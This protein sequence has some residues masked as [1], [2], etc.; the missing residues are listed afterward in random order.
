[1]RPSRIASVLFGLAV[2]TA[3][4]GT[5]R[6]DTAA[7]TPE[8]ATPQASSPTAT[9]QPSSPTSTAEVEVERGGEPVLVTAVRFAAHDG[10]DRV[11]VDFDGDVPGYRV[12]WVDE[13]IE[14]G[15][16]QKI[17]VT[18]GAYL[19]VD[20]TPAN[21]HTE[22]GKPTWTGGPIFQ[23]DLGNVQ[24]VVKTGDFEGHVGV[25][26]VLDHRAGF[27]VKEQAGPNRLVIDVAH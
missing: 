18:G 3:A 24:S 8:P 17:D 14:D 21:A 1:M 15:S 20:L 7:L 26:I 10:Y 11:V 16:G 6:P 12:T 22:A 19:H 5:P 25:G 2:L 9:P 4:C 27:E 13:L 23:A